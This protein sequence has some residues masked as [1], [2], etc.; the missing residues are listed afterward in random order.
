MEEPVHV[1]V[2]PTYRMKPYDEQK[3]VAQGR[4]AP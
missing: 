2:E 3:C 4:A 1:R